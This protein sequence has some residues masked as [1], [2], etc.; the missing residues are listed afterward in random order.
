MER[1]ESRTGIPS[2]TLLT[3]DIFIGGTYMFSKVVNHPD[4][5]TNRFSQQLTDSK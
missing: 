4:E 5:M 3:Y 2:Y 1:L